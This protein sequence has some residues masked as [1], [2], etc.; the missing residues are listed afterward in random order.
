MGYR[1]GWIE[2]G[3]EVI[4]VP[5]LESLGQTM[6]LRDVLDLWW[7]SVR[8]DGHVCYKNAYEEDTEYELDGLTEADLDRFVDVS[9]EYDRDLDGYPIV[10]AWFVHTEDKLK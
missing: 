4:N 2:R 5:K 6:K 10:Y 7:N 3:F 9:N 1:K 8:I